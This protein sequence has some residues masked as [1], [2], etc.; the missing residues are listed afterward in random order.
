MMPSTMGTEYLFALLTASSLPN[1][2]L[3]QNK[4]AIGLD[5]EH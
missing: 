3:V 5:G 4:P 2:A 1:T